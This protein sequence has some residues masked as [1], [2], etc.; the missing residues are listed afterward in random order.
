MCLDIQR[1]KTSKRLEQ[2]KSSAERQRLLKARADFDRAL[3]RRSQ[4]GARKAQIDA[5][6]LVLADTFE[7]VYQNV[8]ANP[9]SAN[10]GEQLQEAVERMHIEESLGE[11]IDEELDELV[12]KRVSAQRV[13]Q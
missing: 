11:A 1:I 13:A 12:T 2:V 6:M 5:A 8:M 4:L 10:V 7:E 3:T 9:E